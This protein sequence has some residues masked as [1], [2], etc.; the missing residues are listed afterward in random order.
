MGRAA[1]DLFALFAV[2]TPVAHRHESGDR[3]QD[4]AHEQRAPAWRHALISTSVG[5]KS[6]YVAFG[7]QVGETCNDNQ[8]LVVYDATQ[9]SNSDK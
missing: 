1:S 4:T 3:Q 6:Q 9:G 7:S 2:E 8:Q 5:K